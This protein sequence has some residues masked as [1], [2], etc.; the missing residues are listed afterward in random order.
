MKQMF[1]LILVTFQ[2][3][4]F[5]NCSSGEKTPE[6]LILKYQEAIQ[7]KNIKMLAECFEMSKNQMRSMIMAMD[8]SSS[9]TEVIIDEKQVDQAYEYRQ[10]DMIKIDSMLNLSGNINWGNL[11][12]EN[13]EEKLNNLKPEVAKKHGVDIRYLSVAF[14]HKDSPVD[15][16]LIGMSI[17][18]ENGKSWKLIGIP[19]QE[20]F[21]IH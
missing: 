15:T 21:T 7:Q 2:L 9:N 5:S 1:F 8:E 10:K 4:V 12:Y 3:I 11:K 14:S 17:F 13:F 20:N 6:E 19:F 18:K 16:T